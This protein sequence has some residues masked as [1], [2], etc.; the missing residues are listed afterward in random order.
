MVELQGIVDA[1]YLQV[2]DALLEREQLLRVFWSEAGVGSAAP[3]QDRRH[4]G[5]KVDVISSFG[6][7][8]AELHL[9]RGLATTRAASQHHGENRCDCRTAAVAAAARAGAAGCEEMGP[10]RGQPPPGAASR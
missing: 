2:D 5:G 9:R 10:D 3:D 6:E 8:G 4:L 7:G 1:S